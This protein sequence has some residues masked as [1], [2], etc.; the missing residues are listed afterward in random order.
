[1]AYLNRIHS[2]IGNTVLNNKDMLA[3]WAIALFAKK[4]KALK[5]IIGKDWTLS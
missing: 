5:G 2:L 4:I 3:S 1:M